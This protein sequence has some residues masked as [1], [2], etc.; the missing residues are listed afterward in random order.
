MRFLF[1]NTKNNVGIN[2]ILCD[3]IVENDISTVLLAEYA[4]DVSELQKKLA[5]RGKLLFEYN[6]AGCERMTILGT[7][8][9]VDSGLQTDY[10]SI[11]IINED[12][13]LCCIH[14]Q[15]QIYSDNEELRKLTIR[16]IVADIE[17]T[18]KA[19]STDK[20][21]IVGDLNI[22]PYD[23]AAVSAGYFHGVPIYEV[24]KKKKRKVG[25]K[26]YDMFYNPMWSFLGERTKPYGTYYHSGSKTN[27]AFWYI[28]DQVMIRPS[29]RPRFVDDN[30]KILTETS[31]VF[32]LNQAG[33]PNKKISDHLPIMFEVE[34]EDG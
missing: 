5:T 21:I 28:L 19:Y 10:A 9:H 24:A 7:N 2:D 8:L 14:L 6:T 27:N 15:S 26:Y 11:Q 33:H 31:S 3:L 32:L 30:L 16:Q 4:A 12:E 20:T 22:A 34:D 23:D 13:I 25:K 17:A 1:W 29:L 18:E